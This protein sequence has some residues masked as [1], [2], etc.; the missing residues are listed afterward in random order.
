MGGE[1][2]YTAP[3]TA[4]RMTAAASRFLQ[5]LS[6][7][8]QQKACFAFGDDTHRRGWSFLPQETRDGVPIGDLAD[9]QRKLAHE[10]IVS[11]TSML[12]YAKVVSIIALEHVVRAQTAAQIPALLPMFDPGLY[13]IKI[14]GSPADETWGWSLEGHHVVL[15]YTIGDGVLIA[16]T[17]C[18]LGARPATF[19][20][21][22]PLADD[23]E[24]GYRFIRSLGEA[25]LRHAVIYH[26]PPP[27]F[28][29]RMVPKIGDLELP[30]HVFVPE[31]DYTIDDTERDILSYIRSAPK[32]LPV[33]ALEPG[34]AAELRRIVEGYAGRLPDDVATA[35]MR[36]IER[37]G[38]ENLSFAWAGSTR[39]GE[40][41][42]FRIQGPE[43]LIEHD[44]TQGGGN[45]IHTVWRDTV[46]DFGDDLLARH[47]QQHHHDPVRQ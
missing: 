37:A 9:D 18:F 29:T 47:Y 36:N 28:A 16:P 7:Q 23:E 40:R 45:H 34:Q 33:T 39:P 6:P 42:Y 19:G 21:L 12:G 3:E 13:S 11:G 43:L 5:A 44:N 2:D 41:H 1:R 25:Q 10:L 35:A 20:V 27:D 30:D 31:P 22:A 17:P 8:Q 38:M 32:G 4:G 24:A 14:F 26:R 15:N 46:N